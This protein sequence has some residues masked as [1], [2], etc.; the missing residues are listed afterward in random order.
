MWKKERQSRFDPAF[1][2]CYL[3]LYCPVYEQGADSNRIGQYVR[4]W[5]QWLRSGGNICELMK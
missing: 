3:Y 1:L 4:K 2:L 5:L